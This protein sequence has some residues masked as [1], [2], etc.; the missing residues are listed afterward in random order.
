MPTIEVKDI[1]IVKK[2]YNR[3]L[4][5]NE[6][7]DNIAPAFSFLQRAFSEDD[8]PKLKWHYSQCRPNF[9]SLNYLNRYPDK[10]NDISDAEPENLLTQHPSFFSEVINQRIQQRLT[11]CSML[12]WSGE[13]NPAQSTIIQ[14]AWRARN[15]L[16]K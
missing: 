16:T 4:R 15:A 9:M 3:W 12:H 14:Q 5:K 7:P 13:R 10:E 1:E 8:C 6:W 2:Q 11:L